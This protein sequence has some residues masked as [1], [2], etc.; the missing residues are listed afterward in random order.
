VRRTA[1]SGRTITR[2]VCPDC[3]S[4]LCSGRE[5][6]S[7]DPA[8]PRPVRA[9]TLD[10]TSWVEPGVHLWTRSKQKWIKLPE[11]S[12]IFATQPADLPAFF[13]SGG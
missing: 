10:D 8:A 3:G 5:F 7:A 9:G 13:V 11:S 6:G 4:W 12:R 2:W 1:D